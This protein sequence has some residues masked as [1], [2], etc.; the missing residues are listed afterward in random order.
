MFTTQAKYVLCYVVGSM[1]A[2]GREPKSCFG[3]VFNFK[4]THFVLKQH[5][6]IALMQALLELKTRPWFCPV[7]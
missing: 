6:C 1:K 7:N 5:K 4:L 3:R 2:N